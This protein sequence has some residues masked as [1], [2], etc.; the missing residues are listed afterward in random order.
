MK[1]VANGFL[2]NGENSFIFGLWN[3]IEFVV[4]LLNLLET[5][6]IFFPFSTMRMQWVRSLR[7]LLIIEH[8]ESIKVITQTLLLSFPQ[9][10][11]LIIFAFI[12]LYLFGLIATKFFKNSLA[13]CFIPNVNEND[14]FSQSECFD[15]GGDWLVETISFDNML[16]SLSSLFVIATNEGWFDIM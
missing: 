3:I 5:I 6:N 8:I 4:F 15:Y 1:I 9:L 10:M 12:F 16:Y 2:L 14:I 13:S 11:N 7:L